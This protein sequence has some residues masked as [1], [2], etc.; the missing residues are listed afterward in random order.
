MKIAGITALCMSLNLIK[1][2]SHLKEDI[3]KK[4]HLISLQR[5]IKHV[6]STCWLCYILLIT[7][8]HSVTLALLRKY[9]TTVSVP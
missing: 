7:V 6:C 1:Y 9:G 3:K 4:K 5:S 8:V 2:S